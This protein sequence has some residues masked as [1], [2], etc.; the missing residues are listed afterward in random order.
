MRAG[1]VVLLFLEGRRPVLKKPG[2]Y[3]WPARN[4]WQTDVRA[5]PVSV[6]PVRLLVRLTD[7][8]TL[9]GQHL[10]VLELRVVVQF[11][12]AELLSGLTDLAAAHQADLGHHLTEA[13]R[14]TIDVSVRAAV[15]A[16]RRSD[17]RRQTL[18]NV[19]EDRWVPR[20]F[21]GGV[22]TRQRLELVTETWASSPPPPAP[23]QEGPATPEP[24][25]TDLELSTDVRL[26]RL[27]RRSLSFDPVG[28][29]GAQIAGRATVVAVVDR[30]PPAFETRELW[31]HVG[32]T[33]HDDDPSLLIVHGTSYEQ[34]VA[35]WFAALE[36][37]A[38]LS[39]EVAAEP[40]RDRLTIK[41]PSGLSIGHPRW[42]GPDGSQVAALRRLLPHRVVDV[43]IDGR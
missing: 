32:E 2:E 26:R 12:A 39:P 42:Q 37:G 38:G 4:P 8:R 35:G 25:S 6:E 19:L 3:V 14:R 21:A 18:L 16:N 43:T 33:Y 5:L 24:P 36:V 10:E 13:V 28:I 40:N 29:A 15:G 22:L 31:E 7:L 34:I 1:T 41:L 9:D 27:W 11:L 20:A 23:T 30:D 17:L